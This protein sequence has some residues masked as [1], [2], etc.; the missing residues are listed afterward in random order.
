MNSPS[1]THLFPYL[2]T[3]F[4][5]IQLNLI[6]LNCIDETQTGMLHKTLSQFVIIKLKKLQIK[7]NQALKL[8]W[9][10]FVKLYFML[11]T[12][13]MNDDHVIMYVFWVANVSL[14]LHNFVS[15]SIVYCLCDNT[16]S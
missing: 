4:F 15:S 9:L 7:S 5:A 3:F 10:Y 1:V 6:F 14:S 13:M 12:A 2:M 8:V 16:S 11:K